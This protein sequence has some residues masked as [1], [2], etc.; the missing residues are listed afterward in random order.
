VFSRIHF[1]Q[2]IESPISPRVSWADSENRNYNQGNPYARGGYTAVADNGSGGYNGGGDGGGPYGGPNEYEMNSYNT[3]P[4]AGGSLN[5]FFSEV[6][7]P[8]GITCS[9]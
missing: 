4:Q 8:P 7:H 9:F 3:Q 1:A 2:V 5:D 6:N